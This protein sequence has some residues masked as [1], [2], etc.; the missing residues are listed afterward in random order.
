MKA[1][2]LLN[3]SGSGLNPELIS[4]RPRPDSVSIPCRCRVLATLLLLL[5]LCTTT[6]ASTNTFQVSG[7]FKDVFGINSGGS[8]VAGNYT[9]NGTS[10]SFPAITYFAYNSTTYYQFGSE[11][12][13]VT[14]CTLSTSAVSGTITQVVVRIYGAKSVAGTVSVSVGGTAFKCNNKTSASFT[15]SATNYTFTGSASGALSVTF[16]QT[17]SKAIYLASITT[18]YYPNTTVTLDKNGGDANGS[19]TFS[20]NATGYTTFSAA[21]RAGYTCTGY[22]TATSSGTKVLNANGTYAT[23][24]VSGWYGS[25]KWSRDNATGTLYAQWESAASC[26]ANPTIGNASLNG[27]F[28]WTTLFEPVRPCVEP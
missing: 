25:G 15:N 9:V 12:S 10:W 4:K 19:A 2:L 14:S 7:T 20:Y 5:A 8:L 23:S 27:S 17:T 11:G 6:W 26:E 24:S 16:G 1:N 21:T 18:T 22:W 3:C 13:P 28:F